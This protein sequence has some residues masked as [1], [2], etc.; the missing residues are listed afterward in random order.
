[1]VTSTSEVGAR[2]DQYPLASSTLPTSTTPDVCGIILSNFSPNE[3]KGPDQHPDKGKGV[4]KVR[5][6]PRQSEKSSDS[7]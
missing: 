7:A 5:V 4:A 3:P 2:Q 6:G 1:M